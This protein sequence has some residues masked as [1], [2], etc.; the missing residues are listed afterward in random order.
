MKMMEIGD[1]VANLFWI[2]KLAFLIEGKF[3]M[4]GMIVR[5]FKIKVLNNSRLNSGIYFVWINKLAFL[6]EDKH[7]LLSTFGMIVHEVLN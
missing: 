1:L 6:I 4:F 3:S 7:I 2:N 5:K